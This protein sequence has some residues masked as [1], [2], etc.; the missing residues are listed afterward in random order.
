MLLLLLLLCVHHASA[1]GPMCYK[2]DDVAQASDCTNIVT[3]GAHEECFVQRFIASNLRQYFKLGCLQTDVCTH[4]QESLF[5]FGFQTVQT[6]G[7]RSQDSGPEVSKKMARD[8]TSI[9]RKSRETDEDMVLCLECS[10]DKQTQI[11]KCGSPP[12]TSRRCF[13]CDNVA[14]PKEC[15][16][17]V[18]CG[19]D[20]SCFVALQPLPIHNG[21]LAYT[22]G[23]QRAPTCKTLMSVQHSIGCI[24]CCSDSYCNFKVCDGINATKTTTTSTTVATSTV[25]V[26]HRPVVTIV[27]PVSADYNTSMTL[28]CQTDVVVD[29]YLWALDGHQ[30]TTAHSSTLAIPALNANS[31]GTYRCTAIKSGLSGYADHKVHIN[32]KP[33]HVI[34]FSKLKDPQSGVVTFA[35]V[36]E[37]YPPP[38]IDW[39]FAGASGTDLP[40]DVQI[41]AARSFGIIYT[42]NS[43][44]HDGNYKCA[45]R[46]YF[47][48]DSQ[49]VSLP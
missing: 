34:S 42:Y 24:E 27:G 3:C 35:C 47:G 20:E 36:F 43:G 26:I 16:A 11:S 9:N 19:I 21:K 12:T 28:T 25:A 49:T 8:V 10:D 39:S 7:K 31:T 44:L 45:A 2:C 13:K 14:S 6:V 23:C 46:N 38:R 15:E 29:S 48:G 40:T 37:G 33:G 4:N 32:T 1:E 5:G 22:M 41:D 30:L 17:I 18:E